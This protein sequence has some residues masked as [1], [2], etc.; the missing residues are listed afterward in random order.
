MNILCGNRQKSSIA[1]CE[2]PE[3]FPAK[4]AAT[5]KMSNLQKARNKVGVLIRIVLNSV[6]AVFNIGISTVAR[7]HFEL[8]W[9]TVS[10]R[11]GYI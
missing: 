4:L 10:N 11:R 3:F 1:N 8:S 2:K 9:P 6:S 5:E 7:L